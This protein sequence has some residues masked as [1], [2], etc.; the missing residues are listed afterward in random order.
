M[1]NTQK[2]YLF[3]FCYYPF[4]SLKGFI[5]VNLQQPKNETHIQSKSRALGHCVT[6]AA[7]SDKLSDRLTMRMFTT[8]REYYH[9]LDSQ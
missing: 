4:R 8:V 3:I 9:K 6:S 5:T 1:T 2:S 7:V